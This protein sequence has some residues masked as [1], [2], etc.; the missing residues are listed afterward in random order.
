MLPRRGDGYLRTSEAAELVGV[1]A[2]TLSKW[3]GRGHI[4]PDGLDEFGK[5]LYLPATVRSAERAVRA[6][7]I[8]TTGIDPRLLRQSARNAET[9]PPAERRW[10]GLMAS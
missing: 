2:S 8:A 9:A 4:Q 6:R 5:P 7:G 10:G 1:S 3:K